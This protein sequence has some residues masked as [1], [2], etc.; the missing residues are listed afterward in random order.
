[1]ALERN[2]LVVTAIREL[3]FDICCHGRRWI[4]HSSLNE[5][6][7]RA[8]IALAVGT[9]T[10]L[11][12]DPPLGWYCRYGPSLNTRRLLCEHGGFLYDSDA[13]ND[14]LPYWTRVGDTHH[15]IVP[16]TLVNNDARFIRGALATADDFFAYLR[17]AFDILYQEGAEHPK[18]MSVGLHMRLMGHPGRAAALARFLDHVGSHEKVWV[19]RRVDIARHW[20]AVH[21]A[22]A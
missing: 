5:N 11:A 12:G 15:L 10:R 22:S 3:G 16:Y 20:R 18:M 2:P 17:D 6:E 4:M 9:I 19:C 21:P 8:E 14:E 1:V 13:Y 7:E